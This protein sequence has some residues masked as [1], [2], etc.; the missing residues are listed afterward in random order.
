MDERKPSNLAVQG[1]ADIATLQA[2]RYRAQL[3]KHF[4][5]KRPVKSDAHSGHIAFA[6]GDCFLRSDAGALTLSLAAADRD[7]RAQLRD[8]VARR[9][10]RFA[11]REDMKI[12]W[13]PASS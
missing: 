13:R 12:D 3:C 11:F 10:L 7:R 2:E 6:V 1:K 5:Q 8:V 4:H 9:L